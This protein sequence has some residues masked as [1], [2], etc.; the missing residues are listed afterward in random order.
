M[1]FFKKTKAIKD[2]KFTQGIKAALGKFKIKEKIELANKW[3]EKNKKRTSCI[4]IGI[5]LL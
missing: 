5:L 3:A 1:K 2:A 4:T